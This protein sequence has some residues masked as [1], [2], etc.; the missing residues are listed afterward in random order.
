MRK[1]VFVLVITAAVFSSCGSMQNSPVESQTANEEAFFME[2]TKES[3]SGYLEE[4]LS[5]DIGTGV[6]KGTLLLPEG[7]EPF[8]AVLIIAGSGPTDRDGNS[9]ML[10]GKNNSLRMLAESL[11]DAGIASLRT[12]K[13][14]IGESAAALRSESELVFS[15]YIDD[16]V[17][18]IN[19]LLQDSR[20]ASVGIIGHSEGS[21][22]GMA[23]ALHTETA[24]MINLAG[25]GEPAYYTL[26]RQLKA[27]SPEVAEIAI[28][29]MDSLRAGEMV[30]EIPAGFESLFRPSIQ[31][32]LISWFSYD[33]VQ[34]IGELTI[35]LMIVQGSTDLQ[36]SIED[37][38]KLREG[39]AAAEFTV[40]EGMNHVLKTAPA[41]QGANLA[42]YS[43]PDLPLAEGLVS[44]ITAFIQGAQ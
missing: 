31:P 36:V 4:D 6:L 20:I 34:L 41:D 2:S 3:Y 33:P 26:E 24:F 30:E 7:T 5:L 39:N 43:D 13:R 19:K 14:G 12:D 32:Y 10:P 29:I 22:I 42:A 28:S 27:Q 8:P 40:I 17:Q 37:A 25:I 9:P 1:V 44:A 15:D 23:A 18:W 16:Y 38:E 35:P 21:L 11:A